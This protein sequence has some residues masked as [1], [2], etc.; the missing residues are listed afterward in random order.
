MNRQC[1]GLGEMDKCCSTSFL[2]LVRLWQ[3]NWLF[4]GSGIEPPEPGELT[5][6]AGVLQATG[7]CGFGWAATAL[8]TA[9]GAKDEMGLS[10]RSSR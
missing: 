4:A 10:A 1:L 8:R 3:Q 9:V 7:G 2:P 5:L 6:G